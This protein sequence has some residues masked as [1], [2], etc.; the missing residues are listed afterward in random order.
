MDPYKV[1]GLEPGASD[2]EVKQAYRRLAKK[3]H[4]DLNPGDAEAA[5]KMQEVNEAYDR[6]KNP[7]KYSGPTYQNQRSGQQGGYEPFGGY[8]LQDSYMQ[9]LF[10][11][12]TNEYYVTI[13]LKDGRGTTPS[14]TVKVTT[15][16]PKDADNN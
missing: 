12:E 11:G 6:I 1:L 13:R 4:P 14:N 8:W 16:K 7:E 5:R 10:A 9:C 15:P 3:Y 2:E